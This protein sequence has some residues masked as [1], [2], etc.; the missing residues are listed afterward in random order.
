MNT[1]EKI[2][3]TSQSMR[4]RLAP[5]GWLGRA[6]RLSAYARCLTFLLAALQWRGEIRQV[7]EALPHFPESLDRVDFVNTM[8][9][10]DFN[11]RSAPIALKNFDARLAP[12]LFVAEKD[13]GRES[14]LVLFRAKDGTVMAYDGGDEDIRALHSLPASRGKLFVFEPLAEGDSGREGVT[15]NVDARVF[16]WFRRIM[17]R[18]DPIF[19]QILAVSFVINLLAL[20][21]SLFIMVVYDKVIGS[22]SPDTL[23]Y[24][25]AGALTAIAFE[26]LLRY[27]RARSLAFFGVRV[28]AIISTAIF[29]RLLFFPPRIIEGSPIPAQ[30]ARMR[31]FESV[32]QFFSGPIGVQIIDLPYALIFLVTIAVIGGPLVVVPVL[33]GALY[34]LLAA[35]MLPRINAATERGAQ[36]A[37]R[38]QALLVET[39]K[40]IRALKL[41]GLEGPWWQ[42]YHELS[43]VA[44]LSG[45]SSSFQASVIEA[46]AYGLS[47]AAGV[48]TLSFGIWLV[49]G[50]HLTTG[51]LIACMM[52]TWRVLYPFQAVCNSL[53]RIRYLFRSIRQV[54]TLMQ[55]APERG[56][57]GARPG[58]TMGGEI[59]F[60]GVGLRYSSEKGPVISGLSLSIQ[61]GQVVAVTGPSG[62]GKSS[63][64]KLINGLYPPQIGAIRIDGQDIR[65]KDPVTLRK[66][67]AYAAQT[68]ELYHGSIEQNLLMANPEATEKEIDEALRRAGALEGIRQ[69]PEGI[70]Q[71]IGDYRSEQLSSTLAF[72]LNLARLYL[73]D[74]AI[75]LVDEFPP[76]VLNSET[77]RLFKQHLVESRGRKTIVYVTD[78]EDYMQHADLLIYLVGDG[79][80]M[81]GKPEELLIA[82][83]AA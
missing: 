71:F 40:K 20:T 2:M 53:V 66:A 26:A 73:R 83:K 17:R 3:N 28:D 68:A 5:S 47:V 55:R 13:G 72:Q 31:D 23:G 75:A 62:S 74:T 60:A 76:A 50:G 21:I 78:R 41:H 39:M 32:R 18:F 29:K 61:P 19:W 6:E 44:S 15:R 22:R 65:Q 46:L 82:L 59:T 43:G 7:C 36:A 51:A 70:R 14:V 37:A 77:G 56:V 35:V 4:D 34:I 30:V 1:T 8:V 69:L 24:F 54:H 80:V 38:K 42:R 11:A 27:L 81:A 63:F 48:A 67:I 25:V 9:H 58:K 16:R 79:R 52:L 57:S 64:L 12:C 10:L 33:L 49:W 45:F